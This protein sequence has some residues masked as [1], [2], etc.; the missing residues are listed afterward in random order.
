MELPDTTKL[1]SPSADSHDGGSP[2]L[3]PWFSCKGI[4]GPLR[5]T[6][7][8]RTHA[9]TNI[10]AKFTYTQLRHVPIVG[11]RAPGKRSKLATL[12]RRIG[13]NITPP[14]HALSQ[15]VPANAANANRRSVLVVR[16]PRPAELGE[17]PKGRLALVLPF[18]VATTLHLMSDCRGFKGLPEVRAFRAAILELGPRSLRNLHVGRIWSCIGPIIALVAATIGRLH[19][20]A[21]FP[22]RMIATIGC[23]NLKRA[24]NCMLH[25][26]S[27]GMISAFNALADEQSTPPHSHRLLDSHLE[28]LRNTVN[29]ETAMAS[30]WS[31]TRDG[32]N[33]DDVWPLS[34][35]LRQRQVYV[36]LMRTPPYASNA[37]GSSHTAVTTV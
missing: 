14:R 26:I 22:D 21:S 7:S 2:T 25:E 19:C 23:R 34:D 6:S 1:R 11:Q 37:A 9:S 18:S 24:R 10:L 27:E 13:T 4:F 31:R 3:N 29:S 28:K 16:L 32:V 12:A 5:P 17:R 15:L 8:T 36:C 35:R 20:I 30:R 33:W